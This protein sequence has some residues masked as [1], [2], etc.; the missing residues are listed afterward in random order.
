MLSNW[1]P[2]GLLQHEYLLKATKDTFDKSFN[3]LILSFIFKFIEIS[4]KNS[5]LP[6]VNYFIHFKYYYDNYF[7]FFL[8]LHF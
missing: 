1:A 4:I 2:A 3:L 7:H 5:L 6:F 8:S